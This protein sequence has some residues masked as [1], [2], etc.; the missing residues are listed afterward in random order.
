MLSDLEYSGLRYSC[1]IPC[2]SS[3]SGLCTAG[4]AS[5][6]AFAKKQLENYIATLFISQSPMKKSP[7]SSTNEHRHI[8]FLRVR[9]AD[10]PFTYKICLVRDHIVVGVPVNK[11][12]TD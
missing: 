9:R 12:Y 6:D 3:I 7:D 1:D 2:I 8:Y 10:T 11:H 4:A 5:R